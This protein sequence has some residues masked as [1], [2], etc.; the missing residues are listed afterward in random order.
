[1]IIQGGASQAEDQALLAAAHDLAKQHP[2]TVCVIIQKEMDK[3]P[4]ALHTGVYVGPGSTGR[5]GYILT[6]AHSYFAKKTDAVPARYYQ[7]FVFFGATPR[8][9]VRARI[10]RVIIHPE[11]KPAVAIGD[12]RHRP[13]ENDLAL[14][15]FPLDGIRESLRQRGIE[16]ALIQED[17]E[18]A[19]AE[20][21]EA[22]IAGCG[23]YRTS[24]SSAVLLEPF[25]IHAG[26]TRVSYGT[27]QGQAG[28]FH[29]R[30][31]PE[32]L[33]PGKDADPMPVPFLHTGEAVTVQDPADGSRIRIQSAA[34]CQA[35]TNVGDS[36]GPL[37]L[38][39]K[40]GWR[41]AGIH[42]RFTTLPVAPLD[43]PDERR[44]CH[45]AFWEPLKADS[46]RWLKAV[47]EGD[48]GSSRVAAY[49]N[50]GGWEEIFWE[51]VLVNLI[52]G[53]PMP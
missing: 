52:L 20:G 7:S 26:N 12:G 2:S 1:M 10:S 19:K 6:A 38:E 51:K 31:L 36:G 41:L 18:G 21:V 22:R 53:V 28:F 27:H 44:P 9:A 42:C 40:A 33:D 15:E 32:D 24:R 45:W 3:Q 4:N 50:S 17:L 37:F 14:L 29:W 8:E 48:T 34:S 49:A 11:R 35:L 23:H 30:F 39:T 43:R 5:S 16:P 25:R 13:G 47:Q 46:L